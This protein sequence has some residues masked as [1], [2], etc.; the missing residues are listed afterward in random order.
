MLTTW[1]KRQSFCDRVGRRDFL[2]V[3]ALGFGGLTLADLLRREAAASPSSS[4]R[5]KSLIYIVLGGGPSHIDMYDLKPQAPVEYRGPF[6]PIET[7]LPGAQ[8][9]E[10]M[11]WQAQIMDQCALLRGVRSVEN[12]HYLSEVYTGLPRSA[13][14][15]PAMG[16]IVSRLAPSRTDLP[17][18]ISLDEATTDVFEFEKPH[19]LGSSHGPF[20]PFGP[21]IEDLAPVE[22]LDRLATRKSL[23][24]EIDASR[25]ELDWRLEFHDLER[26]QAQ[27]MEIIASPRVRDAFDLSREPPEALERYGTGKYPHQT[28]KTILYDWDAKPWVRARR[29]IEAG[30]RVVTMRVG[31][32]DH[33]SGPESDIFLSL[34]MLLPVLD[35]SIHALV[36]DLRERGLDQDTL[37]VVL[38]EFGRTPRISPLGPGREHWADAGCVTIFGGGLRMG[39]VL[40]ATDPKAER[41]TTGDL[42]FQNIMAT[43]YRALGVDLEV[44]LPDFNGRPQYLLEERQPIQALLG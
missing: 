22:S 5:A 39:Q 32:W 14:K 6:Q 24:S 10:L 3:G 34:R 13:G 23:L 9:C 11:P 16:S 19:Y 21:V 27:A 30:A 1:G 12:D 35:K 20:R 28:V 25:R 2:K 7:N 18:Y 42:G 26:F 38:G 40:G 37:V 29:L 33:H 44:K 15:R 31:S 36:T 17:T 43:I 8:I 41:S 4:G